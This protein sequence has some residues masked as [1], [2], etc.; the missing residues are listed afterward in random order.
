MGSLTILPP[1]PAD[2]ASPLALDHSDAQIYSALS[3]D[4]VPVRRKWSFHGRNLFGPCLRWRCDLGGERHAVLPCLHSLFLRL[5]EHGRIQCVYGTHH[6][7]AAHHSL[8]KCLKHEGPPPLRS[9]T[10]AFS[11]ALPGSFPV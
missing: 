8:C 10:T 4:G 1:D 3:G 9:A 7:V 6:P 5:T 2:V 11:C